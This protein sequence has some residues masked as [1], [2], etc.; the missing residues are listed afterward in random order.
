M[1]GLIDVPKVAALCRPHLRSRGQAQ[2]YP[3]EPL[4]VGPQSGSKRTDTH[5]KPH[6]QTV[7]SGVPPE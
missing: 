4:A 5:V 6:A 1:T 7:P 2:L 3:I